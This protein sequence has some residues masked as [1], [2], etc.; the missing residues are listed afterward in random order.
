MIF[1]PAETDDLDA[2]AQLWFDGWQDGHAHIAPAGLTKAR[3]L[4]SFRERLGAA[5]A[6][7]FVIGAPGAPIAFVMLNDDELYQFYVGRAARGSNVAPALMRAAETELAR[8]GYTDVW[9]A[10][11]VGNDR[12]ARFYDKSGWRNAGTRVSRLDTPGGVFEIDI[13]RYEK[14]LSAG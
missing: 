3:T 6:D 2:L 14:A 11:A 12:A 10:C 7:L 5:M 9:L 4:E 13:W 8:R 1:R